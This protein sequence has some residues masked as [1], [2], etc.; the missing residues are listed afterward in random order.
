[1]YDVL[2][3]YRSIFLAYFPFLQ[4]LPIFLGD[5]WGGVTKALM[6]WHQDSCLGK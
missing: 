2:N 3:E 1:M 6:A 4:G 5:T